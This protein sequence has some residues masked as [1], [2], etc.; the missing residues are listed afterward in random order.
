MN[1]SASGTFSEAQP[2]VSQR[3]MEEHSQQVCTKRPVEEA[4]LSPTTRLQDIE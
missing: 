3:L 1:R 2:Q 4:P